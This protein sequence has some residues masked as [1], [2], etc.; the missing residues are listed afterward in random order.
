MPDT[1]IVKNLHF[2]NNKLHNLQIESFHRL[3]GWS[4]LLIL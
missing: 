3:S 4:R 2:E 1:R